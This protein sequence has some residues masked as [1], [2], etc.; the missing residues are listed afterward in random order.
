MDMKDEV[1]SPEVLRRAGEGWKVLQNRKCRQMNW[2][3]YG[4]RKG[5]LLTKALEGTVDGKK[6]KISDARE[7]KL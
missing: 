7:Y 4:M 6:K 1:K 3:G 5:S 2:I